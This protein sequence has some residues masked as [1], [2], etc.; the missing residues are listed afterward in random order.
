[1]EK[2]SLYYQIIRSMLESLAKSRTERGAWKDAEEESE[3]T[4]VFKVAE[5]LRPFYLYAL[6][7]PTESLILS[8]EILKADTEFIFKTV[9]KNGFFPSPYSPVETG[10]QY[11]DFAAF[12]LEF[13]DLFFRCSRNKK[14][15]SYNWGLNKAAGEIARKAFDFLFDPANRL[16]DDQHIRW[17]GTPTH[18]LPG[19][20]GTTTFYTDTYFTAIVVI[21]LNNAI[22]SPALALHENEKDNVK[23]IIQKAGA[24]IADRGDRNLLTGDEKRTSRKLF[25]T[26]WGLRALADTYDLQDTDIRQLI[27][28][29][30][31]AYLEALEEIIKQGPIAITQDY[32]SAC[33]TELETSLPYE[34]RSSWAGVLLSLLSLSNINEFQA[35]LEECSYLHILDTVL[36]GILAL[37]DTASDLWYKE[38]PILSIHSYLAEAFLHLQH[39][40]QAL[41]YSFN[42]TA[43]LVART[44]KE[45]IEDPRIVKAIQQVFY[46]RLN[47]NARMKAQAEQINDKFT[48]LRDEG[49]GRKRS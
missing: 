36:N 27:K 38:Y 12:M 37:R 23:R 15:S 18:S 33:S 31:P 24:W 45:T 30:I 42:V 1:M 29:Y 6:R 2:D 10:D 16:E 9:R 28:S 14:I 25:Y 35:L 43:S 32:L 17:G 41:R 5:S 40:E 19:R 49:K 48:R 13:A 44:M 47:R 20:A 22:E 34:E 8:P 7:E 4:Q 3:G 39:G 26:T 46:E 21:A 11:T